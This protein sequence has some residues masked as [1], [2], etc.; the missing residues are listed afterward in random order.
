MRSS[1][2]EDKLISHRSS[3]LFADAAAA[4]DGNDRSVDES[5]AGSYSKLP[6]YL[7]KFIIHRKT[8]ISYQQMDINLIMYFLYC[9]A[10]KIT[11]KSQKLYICQIQQSQ[12]HQKILL[13]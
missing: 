11:R 3:S 4:A 2:C 8:D 7:Y 5:S 1:F 13:A 6:S 12:Q 9:K 10:N